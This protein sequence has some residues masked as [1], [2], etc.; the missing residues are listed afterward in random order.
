MEAMTLQQSAYL[1]EIVG[2]FA[3]V[4]SLAYLTLQVRQ[5]TR[6]T[7]LETVQAINTEFINWMDMLAS[8]QELAELYHRGMVDFQ[9]LDATRKVQFTVII[10]RVFRTFH[11]LHFQWREGALDAAIWKSWTV[12]F[13]DSMQYPG[14]QEIWTRRRHQFT[15]DFQSFVDNLIEAKDTKTY[16]RLA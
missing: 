13:A 8:N 11:E 4:V 2:V 5:N 9:I 15:E 10:S 14:I 16:V 6:T 3:I 12:T 7:R 1:A